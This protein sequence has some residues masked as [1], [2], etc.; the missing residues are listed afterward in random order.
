MAA[1]IPAALSSAGEA[2]AFL[3]RGKSSGKIPV[4]LELYSVREG[5]K[6]DLTSTVRAVAKMGYQCVEFY[7]P[8][9]DWTE[10]QAKE[11]RKLLDDLG[12]KCYSTHNSVGYFGVERLSRARDLNLALGCKYMVMASSEPKATL[13]QWRKLG[14]TLNAADDALEPSGL[15]V[16]YHNHEAEFMPLEGKRPLEVLADSTKPTVMLQLDVG[17]CIAAGADPVAWIRMHPGRVRSIHCKDWAPGEGK[18]YT[19]LFGEGV[20]DWKGIFAA[21]EDGGGVEYYLVEQEGSRFSELETASKC[22]G[23][24]EQRHGS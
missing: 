20:A 3:P 19:V 1:G 9:F 10:A 16:G 4:G 6:R 21:A 8:Y 23:I 2:A 13:D 5:L 15:H 22:L 7:A 12:V 17:T 24:F 11:I 14:D 18:G